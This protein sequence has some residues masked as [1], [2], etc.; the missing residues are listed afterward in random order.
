MSTATS[1]LGRSFTWPREYFTVKFLPRYLLI[2]FALAGDSTITKD[3]AVDDFAI[4]SGIRFPFLTPKKFQP[5]ASS[6]SP[7]S[8]G[9]ES[10]FTI[11]GRSS[12][13]ATAEQA[14]PVPV[15]KAPR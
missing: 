7:S 3:C 8:A 14:R 10:L 15:R 9:T 1:F 4:D 6:P 2:V 11:L 12:F 5:Q 13:R